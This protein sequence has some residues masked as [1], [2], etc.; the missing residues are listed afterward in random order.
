MLMIPDALLDQVI[1]FV[2]SP[3]GLPLLSVPN[4]C[5]CRVEPSGTVGA[6]G[7]ITKLEIVGFGKNPRQLTPKATATRAVKASV[8]TSL[9]P[10][11][12]GNRLRQ[13]DFSRT[14]GPR[15]ILDSAWLG[16]YPRLPLPARGRRALESEND[17]RARTCA[18]FCGSRG[19]P[20]LQAK[21]MGPFASTSSGAG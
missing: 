5:I 21:C 2:M 15:S 7:L 17:A 8:N 9:R 14:P 18:Q 10:V 4:A 20:A 19:F 3:V 6:E 1:L 12:I 13:R 16:S 11:H